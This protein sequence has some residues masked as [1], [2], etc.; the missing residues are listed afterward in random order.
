[1]G[2]INGMAQAKERLLQSLGYNACKIFWRPLE[3]GV[4]KDA[5]IQCITGGPCR[6]IWYQKEAPAIFMV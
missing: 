3:L 1:M 6:A 5:W 2:F 4:Y